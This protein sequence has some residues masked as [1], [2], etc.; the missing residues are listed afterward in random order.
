MNCSLSPLTLLS[1]LSFVSVS[2]HA[3]PDP[4]HGGDSWLVS[5]DAREAAGAQRH[6]SGFQQHSRHAGRVF[7]S[8]QDR[9]LR[10]FSSADV[11]FCRLRCKRVSDRL[12]CLKSR[13]RSEQHYIWMFLSCL[14]LLLFEPL[15]QYE[16]IYPF[17]N[18]I[19][20]NQTFSPLH[21]SSAETSQ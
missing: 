9:V 1:F 3:D 12:Y 18:V 8:V 11:S 16:H 19:N 4:R 10:S 6:G 7:S 5:A 13:D 2:G 20:N 14:W 17:L 21:W 15:T